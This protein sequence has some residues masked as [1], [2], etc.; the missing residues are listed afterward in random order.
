MNETLTRAAN[1][2]PS[3]FDAKE[4]S[5]ECVFSTGAEIT[6]NDFE[7]SYLERLDMSV[8][9]VDLTQ[10][11]GG[12]VLDNHD[13]FSGVRAILGL[14]EKAS[15]DGTRG[16]AR[17][18]FSTR[19][20]VAEIANDVKNGIIRNVSVGYKVQQWTTSKRADGMRVKTATKWQPFEIS[21]TPL[22]ADPGATVR[23]KENS[24]MNPQEQIRQMATAVGVIATFAEGLI[25][26][27][28]TVEEA[29]AAILE[30][31]VRMSPT[32]INRAPANVTRETSTEDM[33]RAAAD[34]FYHRINTTH[35]VPE[36]GRQFVG[37]RMADY[38]R[39]MLRARNVDTFGSD[40]EVVTRSLNTT[41]DFSNLLSN[42]T[43][44]S[45]QAQYAQAP[46]GMKVVCRR[47]TVNDFKPK[48]ILRRGEMPTLEKV[49][50]KGEFKRGSTVE[51][52]EAY[53]IA[54]YG[55]VFGMTRQM[56]VNDDLGTFS[57]I[58]SGWGMAAV[59]FENQLLAQLLTAGGGLGPVLAADNK[60]MFH[61]DHGNIQLFAA[62]IS[63]NSLSEARLSMRN[64]KGL[65]GT[66]AINA[67]PKFLLVPAKLEAIAEQYLATIYPVTS[68][69]VNPFTGKLQLVVDP[70]LDALSSTAAWYL[71]C[72]PAILPVIE[73]S[74]LSGFEGLYVETRN[75][76]DT[77]G[78][79]IKARLDFGAGGIDYRGA[80]RNVGFA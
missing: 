19:P 77:D 76:F 71:L 24:T 8:E 72:D 22:G 28:A 56:L 63:L 62:T 53:S 25:T 29:R 52:K 60:R 1:F 17:L 70:R 21:F 6:R 73:Y 54:T 58:A 45:L 78:V 40:A 15:V 33:T 51:S 16:L 65:N 57:D 74:Y 43:N 61:A 13:R 9:A 59:E 30:E 36:L 35:V 23:S 34:A 38:A 12:P 41:S 68:G 69:E 4:N 42:L 31:A 5:V 64:Q 50:E 66:I 3:T 67:I 80:F 20:D 49:N 75:G 14:V 37:N 39:V 27:N 48:N 46:S 47:G 44:K 7:G 18:R 32:I 26:R 11:Q 55:K 2:E 79:E 10:L